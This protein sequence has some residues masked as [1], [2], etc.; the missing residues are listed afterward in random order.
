MALVSTHVCNILESPSS[1]GSNGASISKGIKIAFASA[2]RRES[3]PGSKKRR[4][5]DL[6]GIERGSE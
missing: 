6:E 1:L 4:N 2:M 5:I 3:G